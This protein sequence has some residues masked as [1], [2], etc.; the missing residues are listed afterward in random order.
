M[1]ES[2]A[3]RR[4]LL[5][6]AVAVAAAAGFA[7]LAAA[8]ARRETAAAD[9]A[10]R[11]RTAAPEGHPARRAAEAAGPIGKWST[12]VPMALGASAWILGVDSDDAPRDWRSRGAGAAAVLLASAAATALNPALDHLPQPPAP[13]GR[14][15]GKP[16]FPS[17][18]AFG[19]GAVAFTAAYVMVRE[20]VAPPA[21]AAVPVAALLPLATA[22]GR[23]LQE[24]H[25]AS[26]V[27]G[28]YLGAIA[29]AAGCAAAYEA[30][31]GDATG[32]GGS[33]RGDSGDDD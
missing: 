12:Y 10:L 25:W 11:E 15:P 7:A 20:G 21:A 22:G 1:D 14:P 2:G 32:R 16:V 27:A 26:D 5:P 29:L 13:P 4:A 31:R 19:P 18:H 30:L 23:V 9:E 8:V 24:K 33:A 6:A 28:G 3:G 17:G